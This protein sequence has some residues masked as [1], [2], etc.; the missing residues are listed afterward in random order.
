[1]DTNDRG[2]LSTALVIIEGMDIT[3]ILPYLKKCVRTDYPT[4]VARK[5]NGNLEA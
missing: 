2:Q 4:K 5:N 3:Y 1:M